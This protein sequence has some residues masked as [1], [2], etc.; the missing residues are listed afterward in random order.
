[1]ATP[2]N[3][4]WLNV[5]EACKRV[6]LS[7][8]PIVKAIERGDLASRKEGK[9]RYVKLSDVEAIAGDLSEDPDETGSFDA[10]LRLGKQALATT[11]DTVKSVAGFNVQLGEAWKHLAI[12]PAIELLKMQSEALR[13][14]HEENAKL[15]DERRDALAALEKAKTQE[16]EREIA[17]AQFLQGEKRKDELV[18]LLKREI[19]KLV[20]AKAVDSKLGKFLATLDSAQ[21]E[22]LQMVL[23]PEQLKAVY[24]VAADQRARFNVPLVTVQP[25]AGEETKPNE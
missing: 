16:L 17:Q 5:T 15:R 21:L 19:P 10:A 20:T 14:A 2:D 1:M 11:A 18:D 23:E 6:G 24:E 4:E 7:R 3:D 25:Q 9:M 13:A 22:M 12:N 8:T